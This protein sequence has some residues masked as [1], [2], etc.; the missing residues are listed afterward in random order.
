M[1]RRYKKPTLMEWRVLAHLFAIALLVLGCL[2]L[3]LAGRV[4]ADK[5]AVADGLSH[6]GWC[7][8]GGSA[9]GLLAWQLVRRML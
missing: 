7:C 3:W 9:I 1:L 6:I 4:P 5:P 8:L 2:L